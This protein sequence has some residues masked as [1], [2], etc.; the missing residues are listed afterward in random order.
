MV[1]ERSYSRIAEPPIRGLKATRNMYT[2]QKMTSTAA[3][4][5][6]KLILVIGGTG[7]Q[8]MPVV[9]ALLAPAQD[10]SPSPY[11]VRVLTRN[12]DSP[13]AKQ[14]AAQGVELFKGRHIPSLW[15]LPYSPGYRQHG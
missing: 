13:R 3:H 5:P 12:P 14:L 2:H 8:G 1:G 9:Q 10:G 15:S 4:A 11:A 6:N 7:A